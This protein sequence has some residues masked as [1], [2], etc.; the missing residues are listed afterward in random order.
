MPKNR[1]NKGHRIAN[2]VASRVQLKA[3]GELSTVESRTDTRTDAPNARR[4]DMTNASL[5]ENNTDPTFS[6]RRFV[7]MIRRDHYFKN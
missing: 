4:A 7:R 3:N 1:E 6:F 2:Y 5:D